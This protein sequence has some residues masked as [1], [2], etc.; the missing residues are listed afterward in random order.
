MRK[1]STDQMPTVTGNTMTSASGT[2]RLARSL[3]S[4]STPTAF[5]APNM[6]PV[7]IIARTNGGVCPWGG[8]RMLG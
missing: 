5:M 1:K 2:H 8:S 4:A 7:S 6:K 3:T